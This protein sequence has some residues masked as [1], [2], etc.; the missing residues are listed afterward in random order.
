MGAGYHGGFG[1]TKGSNPAFKSFYQKGENGAV[2]KEQLL[3]FINGVTPESSEI[4][5]GIMNGTIKLN[6]LGDKLFEEYLG[7]GDDVAGATVGNQIYL[8]RSSSSIHSD[9]VHE[10]KHALDFLSGI[11]TS[12]ISSW[13]GEIRAYTAEHFFQKAKGIQADFS[14]E[15]DIM[16]YVWRYYE[17][18]GK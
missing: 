9:F 3:D 17:K 18:G 1:N 11:P 16:V 15:D 10:G 7:V 6:V 4:A 5:K 13:D 8:R 12:E 2:T 14:D